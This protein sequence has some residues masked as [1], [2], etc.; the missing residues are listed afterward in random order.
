MGAASYVT[1]SHNIKVGIQYGYGYFWRQRRVA[2][3]LIQLY[4]AGVPSQVI[5]YNTPQ[6][7]QS[8]MNA[9][10]G[11]YAQDSWTLGRFTINPGVRFEHFNSSI[12]GLSAGAGPLRA[13][14]V[15]RGCARCA[16]LERRVAASRL[17]LGRAGQRQDG[18]EGRASASTCAPTPP[19]LRTPT[20]RTSSPRPR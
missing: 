9:D 2:A 14:A 6:T 8:D 10:Q 12:H 20:I 1:G 13:G 3:D 19:A 11:I 17:R 16:E 5:I 7:S 15:L 18:G 4:R